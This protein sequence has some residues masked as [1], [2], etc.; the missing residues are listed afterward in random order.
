MIISIDV[1]GAMEILMQREKAE[2]FGNALQE[3]ALV[4]AP[5]LIRLGVDKYPVEVLP[6]GTFK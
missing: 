5:E 1:C 4:V 6:C 3:A 2:K